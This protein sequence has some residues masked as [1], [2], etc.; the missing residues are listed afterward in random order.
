MTLRC[1]VGRV[2]AMQVDVEPLT[3]PDGVPGELF[4]DVLPADLFVLQPAPQE[5][6]Y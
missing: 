3:A 1:L 2:Q 6:S 4:P 5:V